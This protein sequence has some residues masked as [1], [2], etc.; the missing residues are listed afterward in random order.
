LL[1]EHK[2][3]RLGELAISPAR[4]AFDHIEDEE[5]YKRAL[6]LCAKNGIKYLSN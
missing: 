2:A 1:N 4:I 5:Q 3:K 6:E